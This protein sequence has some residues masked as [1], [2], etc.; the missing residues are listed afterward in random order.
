MSWK[1]A[2]W[3]PALPLL[4]AA[5][6]QVYD[7]PAEAT[8][9]LLQKEP[10]VMA[11]GEY[12]Q[13]KGGPKV[14][15]SLQRFT[16]QMLGVLQTRSS[17]L[18]VETWIPEGNC[19]KK[20]E[21]VVTHVEKTTQRPAVTEDEIVTLVRRA[22]EAGVKPHA[23]HMSCA[24]YQAVYTP[25]GVDYEKMLTLLTT[26]LRG[27]VE[28]ILKQRGEGKGVI[29]VYGGALHNDLYP[30]EELK[31]YT[32]GPSLRERLGEGYMEIDVYVP[33]YIQSNAAVRKEPWYPTYQQAVKKQKPGK[34]VL[35]TRGPGSYILVFP[36]AA[37]SP[38]P[39]PR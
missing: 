1:R 15:S 7:S 6:L 38:R 26:Q 14:P 28:G 33:E 25:N 30:R 35:L 16:E 10:R 5:D 19:G 2:L 39:A 13:V 23:L 8:E 32:F 9:A 36:R 11:F 27:K 3:L 29:M 12:H 22:K 24:D 31:A 18:V 21:A 34:T 20:E 17:D 37:A 4:L